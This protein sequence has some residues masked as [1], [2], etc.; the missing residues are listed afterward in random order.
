MLQCL[1]IVEDQVPIFAGL[2]LSVIK[3]LLLS[4]FKPFEFWRALE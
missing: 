3:K 4:G 1:L 2:V